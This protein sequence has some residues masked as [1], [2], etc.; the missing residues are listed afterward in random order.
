MGSASA[1]QGRIAY[2]SSEQHSVEG[3][4]EVYRMK[5]EALFV[6]RK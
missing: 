4:V 5:G 6:F 1:T 2:Y 3:S